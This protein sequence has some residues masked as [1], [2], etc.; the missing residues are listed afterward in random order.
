MKRVWWVIL[1]IGLLDSCIH[2]PVIPQQEI[3]F[4]SDVQ[5]IIAG[6]C[7]QSGCHGSTDFQKFPLV[8]YDDVIKNGEIKSGDANHSKLYK[9]LNGN[10]DDLMPPSGKLTVKQLYTIEFWI[11]QGAKNN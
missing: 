7:Q 6:N 9:V 5:P 2:A 3:S 10:D 11:D 8:T 4:R 1:I